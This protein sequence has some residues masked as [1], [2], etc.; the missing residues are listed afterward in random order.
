MRAATTVALARARMPRCDAADPL[1]GPRSAAA[2][3][4]ARCR[5]GR[6]LVPGSPT[7]V[8]YGTYGAVL[9]AGSDEPRWP[10]GHPGAGRSPSPGCCRAP[11]RVAAGA[12]RAPAVRGGPGRPRVGRGRC[13]RRP[14]GSGQAKGFARAPRVAPCGRVTSGLVRSRGR[15]SAAAAAATRPAPD[16]QPERYAFDLGLDTA[17]IA[18]PPTWSTC[19]TSP[20][21]RGEGCAAAGRRS[22]R[23][24][25]G[26][27][28]RCSTG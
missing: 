6:P 26:P 23:G 10:L 5:H 19:A 15:V 13:V 14:L 20:G 8:P 4:A 21:A 11:R 1:T 25:G 24:W 2:A 27:S 7:N 17:L 22:V 3:A 12:H 16:R 28:R 9:V 18:R